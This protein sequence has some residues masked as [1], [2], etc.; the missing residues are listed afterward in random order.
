MTSDCKWLTKKYMGWIACAEL[1]TIMMKK[2]MI[3]TKSP[4]H[5]LCVPGAI[6]SSL[7]ITK[8]YNGQKTLKYRCC[9]YPY[10]KFDEMEAQIVKFTQV[11][12]ELEFNVR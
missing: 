7:S 3:S 9:Y 12:A 8:S 4:Q 10:F 2:M 11:E 5:S 1:N 6:L